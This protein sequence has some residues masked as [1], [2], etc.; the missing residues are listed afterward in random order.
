MVKDS[1]VHPIKKNKKKA[2]VE[3][4]SLSEVLL[5]YFKYLCIGGLTFKNYVFFDLN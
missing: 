1:I 3:F 4:Q 5:F 2:L